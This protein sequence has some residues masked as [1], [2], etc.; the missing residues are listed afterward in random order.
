MCVSDTVSL[1]TMMRRG[2]CS[3][4]I[5]RVSLEVRM[6]FQFARFRAWSASLVDADGFGNAT[7]MVYATFRISANMVHVTTSLTSST[8]G[9]RCGPRFLVGDFAGDMQHHTR[10]RH[11]C[12]VPVTVCFSAHV[13][14]LH[15]GASLLYLKTS[16]LFLSAPRM[17]PDVTGGGQCAFLLAGR[18]GRND[19]RKRRWRTR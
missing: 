16:L 15:F 11:V 5:D 9:R 12:I 8:A 10:S 7:S 18:L 2:P 1:F 4:K 14:C 13:S 6:V 3:C 17:D 19:V